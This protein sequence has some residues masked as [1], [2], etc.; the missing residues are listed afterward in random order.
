VSDM[1][2]IMTLL[3]HNTVNS[4]YNKLIW[5]FKICSLYP[6]FLVS[7]FLV[8]GVFMANRFKYNKLN[9]YHRPP[10]WRAFDSGKSIIYFFFRHNAWE[11]PFWNLKIL[12]YFSLSI[13]PFLSFLLK[14]HILFLNSV[15]LVFLATIKNKQDFPFSL[16]FILNNSIIF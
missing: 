1:S 7:I 9:V 2:T 5:T 12:C 15:L 4:A 14:Y 11:G 16:P 3:F 10:F 8:L 6:E 13:T